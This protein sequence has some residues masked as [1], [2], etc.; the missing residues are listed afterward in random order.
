MPIAL[1]LLALLTTP[2]LAELIEPERVR[3]VDGDTID[4]DGKRFRLV[5]FNTPEPE[6]RHAKCAA[7]IPLG[8]AATIRLQEIVDAGALSFEKV[9]CSCRP[10]THGKKI[11]NRGR[12]CG[13]LF[14]H[15][16]DVK[17]WLIWANLAVPFRCGKT[18][19]P[20]MPRPWCETEE[21]R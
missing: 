13:R 19:C 18:R 4:L 8:I 16:I 3:V 12:G 11:C 17:D 1:I 9:R 6:L 20:K 10:G 7:E 5:G 15:G 14:H 2:A 21:V